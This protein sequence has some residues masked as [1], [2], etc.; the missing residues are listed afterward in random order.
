MKASELI[1]YLLDAVTEHGD[2]EIVTPYRE[3]GWLYPEYRPMLN[4][5]HVRDQ[6]STKEYFSIS[7]C[8]F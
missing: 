1:D 8:D 6:F 2:L 3:E 4:I 5:D 7:G